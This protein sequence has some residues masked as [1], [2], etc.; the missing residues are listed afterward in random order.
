LR[1][2]RSVHGRTQRKSA[3]FWESFDKCALHCVVCGIWQW[4]IH[5][6]SEK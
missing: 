4:V 2:S 6:G 5:L 1:A 3:C